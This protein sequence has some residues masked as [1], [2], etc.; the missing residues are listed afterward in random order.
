MGKRERTF[1]EKVFP[2]S[3]THALLFFT[4]SLFFQSADFYTGFGEQFH[5]G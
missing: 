2:S 5:G 1:P 3:P 4:S